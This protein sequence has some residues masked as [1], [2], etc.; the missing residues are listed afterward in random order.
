MCLDVNDDAHMKKR[1]LYTQP[2][3]NIGKEGYACVQMT[4]KTDWLINRLD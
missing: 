4:D 2:N 3:L 1:S